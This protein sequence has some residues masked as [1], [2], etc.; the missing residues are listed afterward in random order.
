MA[1]VGRVLRWLDGRQQR[2][3]WAA[4]PFAVVKKFGDDEAG[5]DAAL[6]SYYAFFSIIPLLLVFTTVLGY[7][8]HGN[9]DLQQS[10]LDSTLAR[11]PVFGAQLGDQVDKISGDWR[12]VLIGTL[13]ALWAGLAVARTFERALDNVYCVPRSMRPNFLL[14]SL[15]ALGAVAFVGLGLVVTSVATSFVTGAGSFGVDFGVLLRIITVLLTVSANAF[16]F[17]GL[18]S[19]LSVHKMPLR[20]TL[21]GGILAAMAF[22]VLQLVGT[23]LFTHQVKGAQATYGTFATVIGM[24]S[25][26]YLQGQVTMYAAELNVV[27]DYRLWPRSIND[28]PIT[29]LP[30]RA[31]DSAPAPAAAV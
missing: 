30:E 6:I 11:F 4:I 31:D 16:L 24:L 10:I 14:S 25:W 9:P 18:F 21:P 5:R 2:N 26:F 7:V 12:A 29:S 15:R 1:C 19:W 17:T 13:V 22:Q 23:A 20:R 8:L 28:P 27:L 3:R